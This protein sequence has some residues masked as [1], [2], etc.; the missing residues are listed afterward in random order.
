MILEDRRREIGGDRW[1]EEGGG[2]D[3]TEEKRRGRR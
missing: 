3:S 1:V 2:D